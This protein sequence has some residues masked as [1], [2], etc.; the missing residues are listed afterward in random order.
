MG[1]QAAYHQTFY[2]VAVAVAHRLA[3]LIWILLSHQEHYRVM[4]VSL[5]VSA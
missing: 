3:R 1:H 4:P 2:K 5:E